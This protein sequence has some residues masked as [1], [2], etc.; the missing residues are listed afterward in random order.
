MEIIA[1]VCAFVVL[2]IAYFLYIELRSDYYQLMLFSRDR[3]RIK[4]YN[5]ASENKLIPKG[6]LTGKVLYEGA[7]PFPV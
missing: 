3:D 5:K 2:Y 4:T 7:Q 6:P 1:A